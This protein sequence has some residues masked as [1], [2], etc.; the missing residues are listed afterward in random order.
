[1][2]AHFAIF[3]LKIYKMISLGHF[4]MFIK[5]IKTEF[6]LINI[7]CINYVF[8]GVPIALLMALGIVIFKRI[9]QQ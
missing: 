1:M 8:Y 6:Q 4:T 3:L 5:K 7:R 2:F 9:F